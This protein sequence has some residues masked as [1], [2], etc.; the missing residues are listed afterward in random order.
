M[1]NFNL[2]NGSEH[3]FLLRGGAFT[4]IDFPRSLATLAFG[5]NPRGDIVG[6]YHDAS[7][8]GHGFLREQ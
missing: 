5:I 8:E 3:G 6:S 7:D 4:R 1:P 2:N